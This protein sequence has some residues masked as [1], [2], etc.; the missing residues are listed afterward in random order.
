M[1]KATTLAETDQEQ[2]ACIAKEELDDKD[3]VKEE[4][5]EGIAKEEL[6]DK[7]SVKEEPPEGVFVGELSIVGLTFVC[8]DV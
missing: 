2:R 7:D 3:S 6:D 4:P 5:P 8:C 1:A